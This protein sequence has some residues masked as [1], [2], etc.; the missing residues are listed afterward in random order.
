[1]DPIRVDFIT[2]QASHYRAPLWQRLLEDDKVNALFL[3]GE[4][5]NDIKPIDLT[6]AR[7]EGKRDNF[8]V[9]RNIFVKRILIW[10]CGALAH[11]RK[12]DADVLVLLGNMYVISMWFAV[13]LARR[14]GISV[15]FWGHGLYGRE[16]LLKRWLR[17]QFLALAD[18]N[19]VYG[20]YA[21]GLLIQN[22]VE[23]RRIRVVYN[24]LDHARQLV[25]R[26]TMVQ[27]SFIPAR[28]WFKDASVPLLLFVGRMASRKRLD[29]LIDAVR[30]LRDKGQI[31]NLLLIGDGAETEPLRKLA[32]DLKGQVHFYGSCYDE[33]EL[34][35]LIANADLYVSPGNVGLAAIHALTY[36]TPVCTHDNIT[37]QGP[38]V[39]AIVNG[40]TGVLFDYAE[41]DITGAVQCWF[42]SVADRQTV[43]TLCYQ[44]IDEKWN[45]EN[46]AQ[47]IIK[48]VRDFVN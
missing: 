37:K 41:M 28:G 38:E 32:N 26:D 43:R 6:E 34:G 42:Y 19:L 2:S 35:R 3:S 31:Y 27:P 47:L 8:R 46:Q 22:G 16:G 21:R 29:L 10:Q 20:E 40:R 18:C 4:G 45:T 23:P 11:V 5:R 13:W 9:L 24:S 12:T 7:W 15:L 1:M 17:V 14:R 39:E 33:E 44:E 48:A 30:S 25:L 36:G